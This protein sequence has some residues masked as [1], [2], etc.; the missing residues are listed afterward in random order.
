MCADYWAF[1]VASLGPAVISRI[2]SKPGDYYENAY[3]HSD[4]LLT[5]VHR[6]C[7]SLTCLSRL[8][9]RRSHN[10]QVHRQPIHRRDRPPLH[11]ERLR[12]GNGDVGGPTRTEYAAHDHLAHRFHILRWGA[13]T[14]E[15]HSFHPLSVRDRVHRCDYTMEHCAGLTAGPHH[16]HEER[17]RRR[18]RRWPLLALRLR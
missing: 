14:H 16:S 17:P 15:S 4:S 13:D 18:G 3:P 2:G 1:P 8:G 10:L 11:H 9:T 5:D 6:S 12:D 7:R